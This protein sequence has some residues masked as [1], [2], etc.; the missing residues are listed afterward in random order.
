MNGAQ[1]IRESFPELWGIFLVLVRFLIN[2][3]VFA[4]KHIF[5]LDSSTQNHAESSKLLQKD[6]FGAEMYE[7]ETKVGTWT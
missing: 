3:H 7:I 1:S 5:F 6:S 4:L 2:Y